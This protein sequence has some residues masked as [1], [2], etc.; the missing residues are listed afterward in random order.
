MDGAKQSFI[1]A[2]KIYADIGAAKAPLVSM[3]RAA[4][5]N[6]NQ[7]VSTGPL[8]AARLHLRMEPGST[9]RTSRLGPL[10]RL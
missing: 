5:V 8:L 4:A 6:A 1:S 10:C 9:A 3:R 2:S 7:G